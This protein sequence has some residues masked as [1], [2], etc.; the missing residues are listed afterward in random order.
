MEHIGRHGLDGSE[1]R[2]PYSLISAVR[3]KVTLR[4]IVIAIIVF[5]IGV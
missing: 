4:V 5:A 3:T 2:R 1:I